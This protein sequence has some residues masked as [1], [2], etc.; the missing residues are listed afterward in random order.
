MYKQK[1]RDEIRRIREN[2]NDESRIRKSDE[3]CR[4]LLS[5]DLLASEK[6]KGKKISLFCSHKGEPETLEMFTELTD[7]GAECFFPIVKGH[8]IY[9]GRSCEDQAGF[10]G[11]KAGELG[12]P[13]P[14]QYDEEPPVMDIIIIPGIAFSPE[15]HRIG[16]GKGYYDKYISQ[17]PADSLPPVIAP[18]FEFQVI[19]GIVPSAYDIPVDIIITEQRIIYTGVRKNFHK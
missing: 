7:R 12:I 15:G 11:F 1:I 8:H 4:N 16:Y 18:A 10:S 2:Q 14:G 17:Y 19:P 3:I 9:M 6:V 13:E 5:L